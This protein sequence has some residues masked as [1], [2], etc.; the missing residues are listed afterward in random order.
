MQVDGALERLVG[1]G[2]EPDEHDRHD[3]AGGT[4]GRSMVDVVHDVDHVI[5]RLGRA[6][7]GCAPVRRGPGCRPG[8]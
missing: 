7:A 3:F 2:T 1:A 8:R 5:E 6:H 4:G